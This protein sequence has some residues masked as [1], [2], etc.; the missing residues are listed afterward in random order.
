MAQP[1]VSKAI[2]QLEAKVRVRLLDRSTRHVALT[3]AGRVLLEQGRL[4]LDAVTAAARRANRAGQAAPRLVVAVKPGG[5]GGLVR[6]V[7]AAYQAA[8]PGMPPGEVAVGGW[9]APT[10]LLRDGRADVAL[11]RSPFDRR[12]LDLEP[13]LTEPRVAVLPSGHRL[14]GRP[15]PPAPWRPGRRATAALAERQ[16]DR[17]GLLGG[18]RRRLA[19][20]TR[21]RRG[22]AAHGR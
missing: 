8:N 17:H 12:G 1:P 13:L 22:Q 3:A 11:L 10:A 20:R 9:G 14:A 19:C 5:D 2:R 21:G 6:E 18:P 15:A 4:A 16:R 7:I